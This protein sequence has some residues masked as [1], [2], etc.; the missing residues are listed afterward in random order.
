MPE[1]QP[2][3]E[4]A[5]ENF[6]LSA[7]ARLSNVERQQDRFEWRDADPFSMKVNSSTSVFTRAFEIRTSPAA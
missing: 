3:R 4:P 2:P 7:R 1:Q 5:L 6:V